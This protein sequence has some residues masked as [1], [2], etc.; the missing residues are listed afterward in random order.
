M[1]P[2]AT[3]RDEQLQLE[4]DELRQ[5]QEQELAKLNASLTM[6]RDDWVAARANSGIESDWRRAESL[7]DGGDVSE[8]DGGLEDTVKNG[9][10]PK[11]GKAAAGAPRSRVKVNIVA[12][13]TDTAVA[14]VCEI[15]LPVDDKNWGIKPTPV[16]EV[17]GQLDD[18]RPVI[19]PDGQ[20][21]GTVGEIAARVQ[22]RATKA[23]KLMESE[24]DDQLTECQ[25]N[26]EL[27]KVI[28]AAAKVGTGALKG[29]FVVQ[30]DHRSWQKDA[31]GN[32]VMQVKKSYRPASAA[33]SCWNLFPD[34]ACGDDVQRGAGIYERKEMTRKELRQLLRRP[35][36]DH[37]AIK[38]VLR[39]SPKRVVVEQGRVMRADVQDDL[40]EVWEYHGEVDPDRLACLAPRLNDREPDAF[41]GIYTGCLVMVNDTVIAA[42]P[43]LTADD[44]LPYDFFQ[45]KQRDE[46]VWGHGVPHAKE[47]Q[48]RVVN[49]AWRQVMDNAGVSVGPQIV[50]KRNHVVPQDN[51]Y[52]IRGM[53][54]WLAAD[55]VEDVTKAFS[56]VNIDSH[57]TELLK[58]VEVA[59]SL[60]DAESG[61]SPMMQGEQSQAAETL[62]GMT[63]RWTNANG[64]MR[65]RVKRFDDGITRPHL[66][67][68]Y[69]WNMQNSLKD[70]IKGDYEVDARGSSTLIE[71]DIQNQAT[72]NLVQLFN[73]P[74]FEQYLKP[75]DALKATLKSWKLDPA[76]YCKTDQEAAQIDE[77]AKQGAGQQVDPKVAMKQAELQDK[78]ADR[79]FKAGEAEKERAHQEASR[80]YNMQREQGEFQIAMTKEQN[81]RDLQLL[82]MAQEER[83]TAQQ[84]QAARGIKELEIDSKHQLFNAEAA[85]KARQGSGI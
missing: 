33:V 47:V 26:G 51:S 67:R 58:I 65:V 25:Y 18:P 59:M 74:K 8:G 15:L 71:R 2:M 31:T 73:N 78:Q 14:R 22:A 72:A 30:R 64:V 57:L 45:W 11:G 84:V 29:P 23:S 4:D 43:M 69:D 55:E 53:K 32:Q 38:S 35:G 46:S 49:A 75:F 28:T 34:P 27:R 85:I 5:A 6:Q 39:Q 62:G 9:P 20:P 52:V 70:D 50:M 17:A 3:E 10:A 76:D 56:V 77:A 68:Y 40:Y 60:G 82:K 12:Q 66:N 81:T 42:L 48:Q 41:D 13:A 19:G 1:Q 7:Y 44:S 16:P 80:E 63:M 61:V 83:T 21:A 24:I 79:E 36:Y 54:T 37:D